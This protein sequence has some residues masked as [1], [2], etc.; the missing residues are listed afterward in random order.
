MFLLADSIV[1]I[2]IRRTLLR[3]SGVQVRIAKTS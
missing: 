1:R 3:T 2:S